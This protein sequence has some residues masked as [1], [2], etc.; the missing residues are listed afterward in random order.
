MTIK[1]CSLSSGSSGNSTY[2]STGCTSILVDAG[3]AA[4]RII[5]S[6][7]HIGCDPSRLDA[8]LITHEHDDHARG[9]S[10][11]SRRYSIPI[12]GT[13]GTLNAI[14]KKYKDIP[15]ELIKPITHEEFTLGDLRVCPIPISHDAADPVGYSFK[16]EGKK[17]SIVTDLGYVSSG[18]VNGIKDSDLLL[19]EAN[20]DVDMLKNGSYP[21]YLK[22]RILS[23][24]GH[25][26]NTV[27]ASLVSF[28]I[29]SKQV[30][31][32]YLGHL[33]KNN[34]IPE[35]ALKT[36]ASTLQ[37]RGIK[38]NEKDIRLTFRDNVSD[39]VKFD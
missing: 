36:V 4:S 27:A 10:V 39:L 12:V 29:A 22:R 20:H 23:S 11:L 1:F 28:L 15:D 2:I 38:Y 18:V 8:L 26:S 25:L 3:F 19:I 16:M 34:N 7:R 24:K 30:G 6:I 35:L 37:Q 32:I 31:L 13:E 21:E 9:I 17:I 14:K 5:D 33:S